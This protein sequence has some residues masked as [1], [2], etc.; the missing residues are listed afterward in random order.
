MLQLIGSLC[1]ITCTVFPLFA[2]T[3][4][5][6]FLSGTDK[7]NT[8][9][10]DFLIDKGRKSGTWQKINVPS[11]WEMEG[12]GNHSFGM[13][14][15]DEKA[16]YKHRFMALPNW[17][18]KHINLVFEGVL[19]DAEVKL[20]GKPVGT[21]RGGYRRFSFDISALLQS[22]SSNEL[23]VIVY[24]RSAD[25]QPTPSLS[26][27][28]GGIYKPVYLEIL[29][30]VHITDV[31]VNAQV[32]GKLQA[33][34]YISQ[35]ADVQIKA[36][37][38]DAEGAIVGMPMQGTPNES[39][40]QEFGFE[41]TGIFNNV[42]TW[43]AELP[44]RYRLI[45]DLQDRQ[46]KLLH[47]HTQQIGFRTVTW[48]P[49]GLFI[50]GKK[51]RLRGVNYRAFWYKSGMTVDR[52]V[53][54]L[55]GLLLKE[56]HANAV[57]VSL[58]PDSHLLDICDSLGLYLIHTGANSAAL[59]RESSR[60]SIIF[61]QGRGEGVDSPAIYP[62]SLV[63]M[64][65]PTMDN[66][67]QQWRA[68]DSDNQT[69]GSLLPFFADE[70]YQEAGQA[71]IK[72]SATAE[73]GIVS[74]LRQRRAAFTTLQELW[75]PI[76]LSSNSP[77]GRFEGVL[78]ATNR[79]AFINLNQC[80]IVWQ[81]ANIVHPLAGGNGQEVADS[82]TTYA[83]NLAPGTSDRL[84]LNLPSDWE[85]RDL[86]SV[87]IFSP[88]GSEIYT[89]HFPITSPE[90]Y[91]PQL[92]LG[93]FA[94]VAPVRASDRSWTL[95]G[96]DLKVQIHPSGHI[97]QMIYRDKPLKI[98]GVP[99]AEDASDILPDPQGG[100]TVQFAASSPVQSINYSVSDEGILRIRYTGSML[101]LLLPDLAQEASAWAALPQPMSDPPAR[102]TQAGFIR[103]NRLEAA[104]D[105]ANLYWLQ[106][107]T[108]D[109]PLLLM[110]ATDR[111]TL[112][113]LPDNRAA[114]IHETGEVTLLLKIGE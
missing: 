75:S 23:E 101:A 15:S 103:N 68:I 12:F 76:Q 99:F 67:I 90:Q 64:Q 80:R 49:D 62:E 10:W 104:T 83:P 100:I 54:E 21:H 9:Q 112:R 110:G 37:L 30:I 51:V 85:G 72:D 31:A 94:E 41:L 25:A 114:F 52:K 78:T 70:V 77:S 102:Q 107:R 8:S 106:T 88:A 93:S 48:Q 17:Q 71:T 1:L 63:T 33:Q 66:F 97:A 105:Y 92:M 13:P 95:A 27:T 50:N 60:P 46:G 45:I 24:K 22:E 14:P 79:F 113:I 38:Q 19:S 74:A 108:S 69:V 20:N 44:R 43:S 82:G 26:W 28:F 3:A 40:D 5:I 29:P 18:G 87:T 7:E 53:S 55:D 39:A 6:H 81:L 84:L 58:D 42:Q 32:D 61:W 59:R 11:C 47:R 16:I 98:S 91:I 89:W 35:R 65:A 109:T 56:I 36:Y 34:V 57:R 2:Q 73:K 86:L 96:G 4:Q 111:I